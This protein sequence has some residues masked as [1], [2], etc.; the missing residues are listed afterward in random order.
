MKK[1]HSLIILLLFVGLAAGAWYWT[2]GSKSGH[3]HSL[4]GMETNVE[5]TQYKTIKTNIEVPEI[6]LVNQFG[7]KI[8]FTDFTDQD[9]PV[10]LQ[11]MFTS[12]PTI[13]PVLSGHFASFQDIAEEAGTTFQLVSVSIDPEYDVPD[14][15]MSYGEKFGAGP[16][17]MFLTG[18]KD[19]IIYLQKLFNNY[20][21]N[22][23]THRPV[24]YF[25]PVGNQGWEIFE[26]F[27]GGKELWKE[28]QE[29]QEI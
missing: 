5:G 9:K 28:L 27:I 17:W 12:C 13:C 14:R 11:F 18:D 1:N 20:T 25:K 2:N 15:L 4:E 3:C 10:F 7:Q 26:G 21:G 19:E 8:N 22:K 29:S 6:E 23:M 24:T 16:A